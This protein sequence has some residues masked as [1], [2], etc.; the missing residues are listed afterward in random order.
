VTQ[1]HAQYYSSKHGVH[2]YSSKHS[3]HNKEDHRLVHFNR[4]CIAILL[5]FK[6]DM[7]YIDTVKL[8]SSISMFLHQ[9][10]VILLAYTASYV[11]C[12]VLAVYI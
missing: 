7:P 9:I 8:L 11:A 6:A 10:A 4:V 12:M 3:V 2:Y 1:H 5:K